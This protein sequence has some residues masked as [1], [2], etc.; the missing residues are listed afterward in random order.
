MQTEM[1]VIQASV[2]FNNSKGILTELKSER[3]EVKRKIEEAI[4]NDEIDLLA[5]LRDRLFEPFA[6]LFTLEAGIRYCEAAMN[7]AQ[8]V[9]IQ[10]RAVLDGLFDVRERSIGELRK[11]IHDESHEVS[12][13]QEKYFASQHEIQEIGDQLSLYQQRL[14]ELKSRPDKTGIRQLQLGPLTLSYVALI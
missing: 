13:A 11:L 6:E 14:K 2:D 4:R 8:R 1:N 12:A 3:D 10:R 7:A 5:E 9:E